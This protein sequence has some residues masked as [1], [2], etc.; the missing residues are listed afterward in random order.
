MVGKEL[1][2]RKEGPVDLREIAANTT[3]KEV[4]QKGHTYVEL[5][6]NGKRLIFFCTICLTPCY[7]DTVLFDHLKG[8]LHARRYVAAKATLF[9]PVPWPFND[10]VLFFSNSHQNQI[11]KDKDAGSQSKALVI[12]S[13]SEVT[14]QLKDGFKNGKNRHKNLKLAICGS[15]SRALSRN[16]SDS[17]LIIPRVLLKEAVSNL[18]VQLLGIGNV[19]YR[20]SEKD[21][22]PGKITK[23]WCAWMGKEQANPQNES[24]MTQM[25]NFAVVNFSYTYDLGRKCG[26]DE[27]DPLLSAGSYFM[28]DDAGQRGTK[29]K[30]SFSDQEASSEESNGQ[31]SPEKRDGESSKQLVKVFSSKSARRELRKQKRMAAE[32]AC[33]I[34]GQTM[35]HGKDVGALL[36]CK[37][38]FLACSSR[39]ANGAF[40]LFHASC[41][42]HWILLCEYEILTDRLNNPKGHRGRKPKAG[43]KNQISSVLCPECQGTGIHV[44]EEE[45]EKPSISLS[46]MFRHKLKAIEAHKAWMKSPEV[47]E[48][49]STGLYF[50]SDSVDNAQDKVVPLKQM[51][52]FRADE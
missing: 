19:S 47:L 16:V 45:Y 39:N 30:K 50:P 12:H 22:S 48:H 35:L 52:F 17:A 20:I 6:R 4:R 46:E 14:S 32:R 5:R 13:E 23:I 10:G 28:I 15:S 3:L 9:G 31:I 44:H 18:K 7:S 25:C 37:T 26:S 49:C 33:D 40:H 27:L 1:E 41:L 24:A 21:E 42:V 43:Q 51:H 29:R 38:G 8:N 34:C 11:E 2:L 36:N